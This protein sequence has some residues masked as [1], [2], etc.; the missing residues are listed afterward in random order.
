M[1]KLWININKYG[2]NLVIPKKHLMLKL[3]ESVI[4]LA[5]LSNNKELITKI[6]LK[7]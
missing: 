1:N 4:C 3:I 7:C 2:K 6:L 5:F